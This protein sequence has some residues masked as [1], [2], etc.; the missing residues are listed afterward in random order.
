MRVLP[1]AYPGSHIPSVTEIKQAV[2]TDPRHF[3]FSAGSQDGT[4]NAGTVRQFLHEWYKEYSANGYRT[5]EESLTLS[6]YYVRWAAQ[7]GL[8]ATAFWT[9]ASVAFAEKAEGTVYVL[10]PPDVAADSLWH[11]QRPI[12]MASP[13]VQNIVELDYHNNKKALK[14]VVPLESPDD[15]AA[16]FQ[17]LDLR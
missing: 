3:F 4:I 11:Y 9:T 16:Q 12:L 13:T 17:G 15:M 2:T 8:A 6:D 5:L 1:P 14:G 7:G 10:L